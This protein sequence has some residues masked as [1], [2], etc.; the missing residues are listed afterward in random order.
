MRTSLLLAVALGAG[1]G[2]AAPTDCA[3]AEVRFGARVCVHRIADAATWEELAAEVSPVDQVRTTRYL[4]PARDDARLPLVFEDQN[5]AFGGHYPFL[6]Q[7][8]GDRFAALTLDEYVEMI[9]APV[10]RELFAGGI[11]EY[12]VGEDGARVYGYFVWDTQDESGTITCAELG[13]V[14]AALEA[15]FA[16]SPLVAVPTTGLQREVMAACDVASYD[17][18]TALDYEVYSEGTGYG[19]IRRYTLA[20]LATATAAAA[21]NFQDVLVL[22]EAPFDI[23]TV[24]SGAIT[25]TRQGE[26]SHL[27]V[28]SAARGTPNCYVKNAHALLESWQGQLVRI[29]CDRDELRVAPASIEEAEAWWASLR[30]TPVAVPAPDLAFTALPGLTELPTGSAAERATALARVGGKGANLGALYQRIPAALTLDGFTIPF[31]YY[32]AFLRQH[33]LDTVIE[34]LLA[35]PDVATDG[36]LRRTRLAALRAAI[37]A[38]PCD[39]ALLAPLGDRITEIF[40]PEP[41]MVR[42]RSSSNAEDSLAFSGAGLYDSTSACLADDLDGDALGPSRCDPDQPKERGLCRAL[43]RVWAS[44]WKPQAYDERAWYGMDQ[45]AIAMAILV[46]DRTAGERANIVAFTGNPLGPDRANYLVNAQL[47]ELDVVSAAPGVWPEKDLLTI[48]SGQVTA[49]ERAR[50]STEVAP[51]DVVL[52]DAQLGTL[53]AALADIAAQMPLDAPVPTGKRAIFDTEWKL[54]ADGRL[55]IKQIRP[56]LDDAL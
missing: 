11:T 32:G 34:D 55:I 20:D 18:S 49:I 26:L 19:T 47:G 5:A 45:R 37:E 1:C 54:T 21:F 31:H 28:R 12:L 43:T 33:G 27:N 41:L 42:F 44:T 2:D 56:S 22:A 17:P 39:S 52:T 30:P 8:F 35:D 29:D 40:G 50:A 51:G 24:I 48:E 53:G 15:G 36:A 38:A 13:R 14:Q 6:R 4:L 25:G 3:D 46:N 7:A 16:L 9:T 23:E 10:R